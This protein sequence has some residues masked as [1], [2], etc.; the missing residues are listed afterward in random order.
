M[1][2]DAA[3]RGALCVVHCTWSWEQASTANLGCKAGTGLVRERSHHSSAGLS[4]VHEDL[5]GVGECAACDPAA[6]IVELWT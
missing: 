4:A 3:V 5:G 2:H 1:Q 6:R